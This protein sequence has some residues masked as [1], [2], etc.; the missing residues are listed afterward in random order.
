M[1][2][3]LINDYT[4][5]MGGAE[6]VVGHERALLE[7][8]GHD[9]ELFA[10]DTLPIR[11]TPGRYI[12]NLPARRALAE[13]LAAFAPDVIHLHN[14]YHML[15]PG[16]LA[17]VAHH[18]ARRAPDVTRVLLT[19]HDFHL[20]CPNA[21][22]QRFGPAGPETIDPATL[23]LLELARSRWDRRGRAHSAAKLLQHL[24]NY[25]LRDRRRVIDAVLCPGPSAA[26][27]LRS[28]LRQPVHVVPN[29]IAL[30]PPPT[31]PSPERPRDHLAVLFVGRLD[32][33]KGLAEFLAMA[34]MSAA[35]IPVC[36][37]VVGDGP[38]RERC[39]RTARLRGL[40][41][42]FTGRLD[43]HLATARMASAHALVLPS[44]WHENAPMVLFEA[45]AAGCELLV[46]DVGGLRD[47]VDEAGTGGAIT[48]DEPE[49]VRNALVKL[50]DKHRS[51]TINTADH[52]HLLE[53]RS[54][55]AHLAALMHAY[56]HPR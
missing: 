54:P 7:Q 4:S 51:G 45:L 9:V 42:R 26:R 35:E 29:P 12:D 32:P 14:I 28:V 56:E 31:S 40:D 36:Y 47:V 55:E 18:K 43:H 8:A 39:E 37:T 38:E 41:A 16:I 23:T 44:R 24:W 25:R 22:L 48:P 33:E 50:A 15:S 17:A 3:I 21:G 20:V 2:V 27:I 46:T 19:A 30:P 49:S 10:G 13:R 11:R 6:V 53:R 52:R 34:P 5:G 1:R